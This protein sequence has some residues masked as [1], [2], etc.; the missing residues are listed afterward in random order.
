MRE[1]VESVLYV[2][3]MKI[4]DRTKPIDEFG[5]L[6]HAMVKTFMK[7]G[8]L[9][10]SEGRYNEGKEKIW[11]DYKKKNKIIFMIYGEI[12]TNMMVE[13][14]KVIQFHKYLCDIFKCEAIR[15]R[16][17]GTSPDAAPCANTAPCIIL[18]RAL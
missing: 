1:D 12:F 8:N 6:T 9:L 10:L 4:I 7:H 5:I 17:L 16:N 15:L 13:D 3:E 18:E 14:Q 11:D 2:N